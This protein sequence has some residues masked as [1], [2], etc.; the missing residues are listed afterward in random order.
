M[1]IQ[2]CQQYYAESLNLAKIAPYRRTL[3]ASK[4]NTMV[5]ND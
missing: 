1:S 2:I 4:C 3:L 5:S